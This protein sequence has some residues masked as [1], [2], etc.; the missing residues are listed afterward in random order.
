MWG[1]IIGGL[2]GAAG[3]VLGGHMAQQGASQRN[4][5]QIQL[6][7]EQMQ[8]QERMSNTAYQRAMADMRQAGLN[9]ILAYQKGGA[10]TPGGAM[11]SLEN[12]MAGWGPALSGAM[13]SARETFRTAADYK[14]AM[15]EVDKK[16]S[17][18][19]FVKTNTDLNK[20]LETKAKQETVTSASQMLLNNNAAAFQHE[21]A[22]NAAI[23]NQ[24]LRNQVHSAAAEARIKTREAE[25]T[26]KWGS[27]GLGGKA[28][29]IERAGQ[30]I[31]DTILPS[32]NSDQGKT[33]A[34]N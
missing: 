25:D 4:E 28:A 2:L 15:E 8:F 32:R 6:A 34:R 33:N 16:K 1:E 31:L 18:T 21:N 30:R 27:G 23:Q 9:P 11:A 22:L 14:V 7:R 17:E 12:E 13:N 29:T 10:S 5:E 24:I 20:A 3:N 26:E 19:D